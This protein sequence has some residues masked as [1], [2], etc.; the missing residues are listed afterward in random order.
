MGLAIDYHCTSAEA[1]VFS[2]PQP[3]APSPSFD[4]VLALEIIEHVA[5]PELF[6][7]ALAALVKPGGLLIL[8]TLNRTAK[9]Y[10]LAIVGA[11]YV[12]HWLPRGTHDWQQ[13]IKPSEMAA[14]L[15]KRY[16]S[17]A[18][19][20]GITYHPLKR[21]FS[22]NPRDLDVNYLMVAKK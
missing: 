19:T 20:A 1:L 7:Y 15:S 6:Y 10:A 4:V 13:F 8:S 2:S 18:D 21:S 5:K 3:P 17:I 11:E 12:L 14:A 22:I 9:S 16:F